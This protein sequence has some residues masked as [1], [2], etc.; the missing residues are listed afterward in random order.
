MREEVAHPRRSVDV[1]TQRPGRNSDLRADASERDVVA[2]VHIHVD[3]AA[4]RTDGRVLTAILEEP[5]FGA[6][7]EHPIAIEIP[8]E[9]A[10]DAVPLTDEIIESANRLRD[11]EIDVAVSTGRRR[12][13]PARRPSVCRE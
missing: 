11:G 12:S 9:T 2:R 3:A 13:G 8:D 7:A 4:E 5:A 1:W 6:N 10:G